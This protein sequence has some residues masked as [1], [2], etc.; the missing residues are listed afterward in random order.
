MTF[1][2]GRVP[3][4]TENKVKFPLAVISPSRRVLECKWNEI[5]GFGSPYFHTILPLFATVFNKGAQYPEATVLEPDK[6]DV[7]EKELLGWLGACMLS[8]GVDALTMGVTF[9]N[10]D[11]NVPF[12]EDLWVRDGSLVSPQF[13]KTI[14]SAEREKIINNL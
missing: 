3:E 5:Y 7:T 2:L 11:Y 1:I 13:E 9:T 8:G 14:W 6:W 4:V 12:K 10:D